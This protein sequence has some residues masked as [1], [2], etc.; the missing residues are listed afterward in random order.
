MAG[1]K[2]SGF[3]FVFILGLDWRWGAFHFEDVLLDYDVAMNYGNWVVVAEA[4]PWAKFVLMFLNPQIAPETVGILRCE[5]RESTLPHVVFPGRAQ[6][7]VPHFPHSVVAFFFNSARPAS[8]GVAFVRS[9][10]KA[11]L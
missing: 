6:Q 11:R 7:L 3:Y 2:T 4:A 1:R 10:Q 5:A 9:T 8:A